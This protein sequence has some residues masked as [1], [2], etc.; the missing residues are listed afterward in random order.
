MEMTATEMTT[1]EWDIMRII[2][3]LGKASSND[4][5]KAIQQEKDWTES[6][7][8]TLL[9]RLVTKDALATDRDGRRFIYTPKIDERKAMS[10]TAEDLFSRMCNM[11][12][13]SVI[14]ELI[15]S[16]PL[17][18]ADI[19]AM[20]EL[21]AEKMKTAPDMVECNCMPGMENGSDCCKMD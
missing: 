12:K 21:L 13:G 6:T 8:K 1:S 16:S 15:E 3:T 19:M 10:E 14:T 9:R 20:Q 7:I 17:S 11:R 18:K 2:W 4:V 5:I